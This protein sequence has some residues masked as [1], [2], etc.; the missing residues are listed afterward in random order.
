M[1]IGLVQGPGRSI[2]DSAWPV[3]WLGVSGYVFISYSRADR[4]YVDTLADY[5]D[6]AGI[7]VWYDYQVAAGDRW[8][9][10]IREQIDTCAVFIVV[11]SPHSEAAAWVRRELNHAE[12]QHKP[13]LPLLLAGAKFFRLNDI[14]YEDVTGGRMP[15]QPFL[16]RLRTQLALSADSPTRAASPPPGKPARVGARTDPN[17]TK[18][19]SMGPPVARPPTL[20]EPTLDSSPEQVQTEPSVATPAPVVRPAS[21]PHE[22]VAVQSERAARSTTT[23][24]PALR[25]RAPVAWLRQHRRKSMAVGAAAVGIALTASQLPFDRGTAATNTST[26]TATPTQSAT[27][28]DSPARVT[29]ATALTTL[30][31]HTDIVSSVAFSPD[32]KTMATTSVDHT[33]I[34]WDV[35]N[36]AQPRPL[37]SLTDHTDHV[38]SVAFSPD[39]KTMAT[40]SFD[41]TVIV[42]DVSNPTQP[43]PLK[44]LPNHKDAVKSVAFSPDGKTMATASYDYTVIVWHL[45]TA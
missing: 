10:V 4:A 38:K 41:S 39:G 27:P 13:V 5:L 24:S 8:E 14:Q 33:V 30:T 34:V 21:Q 23:A 25:A 15:G 45:D 7:R 20:A 40:A 43:R 36:P 2:Q 11:M 16:G 6:K 17:A 12:E 28:S 3:A 31:N 1:I 35:S 29:G 32:R 19:V 37:K 42:W 22:R 26:V 44:T 9:Q 18:P